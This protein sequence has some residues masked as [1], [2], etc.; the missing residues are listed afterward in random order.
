MAPGVPGR[1]VWRNRRISV[2]IAILLSHYP[3]PSEAQL[4]GA[5]AL[6]GWGSKS[7]TQ[8]PPV[9]LMALTYANWDVGNIVGR[10]GGETPFDLSL[11]SLGLHAWVVTPKKVLGGTYGFQL[12]VPAVASSLELP[13]LGFST[14]SSL[15]L[16]DIYVQPVNLGWHTSRADH[17][18]GLGFYAPT[19]DYEPNGN[20]NKGLGMWTLEL[21]GGSTLYFDTRQH[22]HVSALVSYETHTK[23]EDQN[24]KAG[25][26]LTVEGGLGGRLLSDKLQAR[27]AYGA[28]WKISD[29]SGDDFP[30]TVEPSKNH[31]YTIGPELIYTGLYKAPYF[32]S[33]TARYLW[34]VGARSSFEGNRFV[35]FI[36]FGGLLNSKE[37]M[38][39]S[40]Q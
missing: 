20:E 14:S 4:A 3:G 11:S 31:L 1:W 25:D 33:L 8:P 12:L 2:A 9:V 5:H 10:N 15:G 19:G 30:T 21:S 32:G 36:S 34:D 27:L 28:Q 7:G 29:D 23:K 38:T 6:M 16:S 13:R 26:I 39:T 35:V 37:P 22:Y 24:L 18:V 40:E 17:L